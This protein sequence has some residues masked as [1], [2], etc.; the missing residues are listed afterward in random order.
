VPPTKRSSSSSSGSSSSSSPTEATIDISHIKNS[1]TQSDLLDALSDV[2]AFDKLYVSTTNRAIEC[3]TASG[4]R[5]FA[6]KLHGSLAGLELSVS[7]AFWILRIF[8]CCSSRSRFLFRHRSHYSNALSTFSSLPAHYI[9]TKWVLLEGFMHARSLDCH[10]QLAHGKDTE[11]VG[12]VL[13]FF[14]TL[15]NARSEKDREVVEKALA[16]GGVLSHSREKFFTDLLQDLKTSAGQMD[17][18]F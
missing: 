6:L 12:T 8:P 18:G 17:K 7:I 11:W 10:P 15:I 5:R 3:Y 1:L 13:A 4:R 9:G 14:K 2:E 16:N